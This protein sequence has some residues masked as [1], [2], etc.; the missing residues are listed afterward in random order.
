MDYLNLVDRRWLYVYAERR[1][2]ADYTADTHIAYHC[3]VLSGVVTPITVKVNAATVPAKA[4]LHVAF[5][6]KLAS[7]VRAKFPN[8][9]R[10]IEITDAS[11]TT[12]ALYKALLRVGCVGTDTVGKIVFLKTSKKTD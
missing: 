10:K 6:V 4:L 5:F 3:S 8:T 9:V 11:A 12:Q 7:I 1:D 2:W